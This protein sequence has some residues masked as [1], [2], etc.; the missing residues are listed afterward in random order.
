MSVNLDGAF[1]CTKAGHE[2]DGGE[3]DSAGSGNISSV[4]VAASSATL[5]QANYAASKAGMIGL[6][7]DIPQEFVQKRHRYR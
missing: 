5:G 6:T 1:Y 4:A 7:V 2:P 3:G